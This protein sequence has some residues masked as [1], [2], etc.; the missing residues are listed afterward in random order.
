M[1]NNKFF[2]HRPVSELFAI[3]KQSLRKLDNEGLVDDGS[4]I[5]KVMW[6]NDKLGIPIREIRQICIPVRNYEAKLPLDFEKLYYTFATQ[7]TNTII[8]H[9]QTDPFNNNFDT[10]I[11]YEAHVDR[12]SLGC[13]DNYKVVIKRQNTTVSCFRSEWIALEVD[14]HS[15][16]FCHSSCPNTRKRGRYIVTIDDFTIH[17]PFK[18][19]EIYV[20]YLGAMKDSDGNVLFPFHPLI[21]PYYEWSLKEQAFE[22]AVMNSEGP[23]Y[24]ELLKY[25]GQKRSETYIE[26]FNITL[27][28]GYGEYA[29]A[30]RKKELGWY[31]QYFKYFQ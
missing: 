30:Q 29:E 12:E 15:F 28:K 3:V 13:A 8:Q 22:D 25:A 31:N 24:I 27:E 5:K 19:G 21:T 16:R 20:M 2:T 10:D 7:A 11:L 23:E 14:P 18:S 26:A 9:N 6:C 1:L 17:T 4:L